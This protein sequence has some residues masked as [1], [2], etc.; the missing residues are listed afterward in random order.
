M[1]QEIGVLKRTTAS[2]LRGRCDQSVVFEKKALGSRGDPAGRHQ[3]GRNA[4]RA[5]DV[6]VAPLSMVPCHAT[7]VDPL[8]AL[9]TSMTLFHIGSCSFVE[10]LERKPDRVP[11]SGV[12]FSSRRPATSPLIGTR[13]TAFRIVQPRNNHTTEMIPVTEK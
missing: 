3:P 8:S 11:S 2:S 6:S 5:V 1:R 13:V 12:P 10:S 7:L 9:T 4:I